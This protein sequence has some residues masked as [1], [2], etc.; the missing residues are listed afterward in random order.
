MRRSSWASRSFISWT[1]LGFEMV[2]LVCCSE[3]KELSKLLIMPFSLFLLLLLVLP[4]LFTLLFLTPLF[5][6]AFV[7][8]RITDFPPFFDILIH[9]NR[10]VNRRN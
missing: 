2:F 8:D 7:F 4:F 9:L 6:S 5:G 10:G 3:T 1:L